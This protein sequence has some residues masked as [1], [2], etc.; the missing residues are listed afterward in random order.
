MLGIHAD[1]LRVDV[2][3]L[4]KAFFLGHGDGQIRHVWIRNCDPNP[5]KRV[6]LRVEPEQGDECGE[7]LCDHV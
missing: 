3:I 4:E 6:G 7:D 2:F 1:D 5:V